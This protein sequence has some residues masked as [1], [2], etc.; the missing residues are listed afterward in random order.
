MTKNPFISVIVPVFNGSQHIGQCLDAL[1]GQSYTAYE[2]IV[3]DDASTDDSVE[4]CSRK[5][6]KI[7]K[8]EQQSGPAVARNFGS[9]RARGEVLLFI[10]ADVVVHE[11]TIA[12]VANDFVERPD[13]AAVFGSYDDTPAVKDFVSQYKN[14]MHHYV[15]QQS[16]P[17]ACTFWAGC[18]AVRRE[19]FDKVGGFD[20]ERYPKPSIEDIELGFRL[21]RM[22]N[23]IL[24]DKELQVKHM[25]RW[26]L[27]NLLRTDIFNRAIPWSNLIMQGRQRVNDL[28]LRMSDKIC[29]GLVGL[30]VGILPF[31]ILRI[32][33]LY[34][35]PLFLVIIFILQ[36]RLYTFFLDRKGRKFLALAFPMHLLYFFYSAVT[37]VL[38]WIQRFV[39]EKLRSVPEGP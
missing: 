23:K 21:H 38:C 29:A 20:G 15:H 39:S 22:G 35:I 27:F 11:D 16:N 24:L 3:V 1:N 12:R 32:Q 13:I 6:V 30:I 17:D 34:F 2:I 5:G 18:G 36:R 7:L 10:D 8:L 9:K 4:I 14:L 33:L 37:F 25:K 31:S 19:I 28:N 26:G